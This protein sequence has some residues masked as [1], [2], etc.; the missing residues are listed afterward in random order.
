MSDEV[1]SV[2]VVVRDLEAEVV[3]RLEELLRVLDDGDTPFEV[4]VVDNASADRTVERIEAR[5]DALADVRL[6]CL[7]RRIPDEHA[8][9]AGVER[10]LGDR[11]VT[12]GLEPEQVRFLPTVLAAAAEQDL[13]LVDGPPSPETRLER[14]AVQGPERV[15]RALTGRRI[16]LRVPAYRL[17]S[18]RL[19]SYLLRHDDPTAVLAALPALAT[20]PTRRL[21]G[22]AAEAAPPALSERVDLAIRA[23]LRVTALPL[24]LMTLVSLVAG[25]LNL[26]YAGYVVA[27]FLFKDHVQEGWTTLSLQISGMFF[28]FSIV[29]AL[30]SEYVVRIFQARADQGPYH[31][32]RERRSPSMGRAERLNVLGLEPRSEETSEDAPS[33]P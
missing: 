7:S 29:L 12:V 9:F 11:V 25:L 8:R 28:L 2:V 19:V 5:L 10:A 30:L 32:A 1:L 6:V 23:V 24:R 17:H 26:L 27:I 21:D 14:A 15:V 33:T 13:V 3:E 22:P 31:V 16:D 18:R 4:V 20:F